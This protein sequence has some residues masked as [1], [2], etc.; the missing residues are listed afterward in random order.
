MATRRIYAQ[1]E[2]GADLYLRVMNAAG[3]WLDFD[4]DAFKSWSSATTPYVAMTEDDDAG[5][6]SR[7][8]Y[9]AD[10][11]LAALN[12]TPE[13]LRFYLQACDNA[14]PALTDDPVS[15]TNEIVVQSGEIAGADE[16]LCVT[17]ACFTSTAGTEI[18]F[19]AW[20]EK[21]GQKVVL[22]AGSCTVTVREHGAGSDLFSVTDSAPNAAGVFELTQASPGFTDDRIYLATVAITVNSITYTTAHAVQVQSS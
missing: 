6:T 12:P 14:S 2:A 15:E 5:G 4:D 21:N 19:L 7:K 1:A 8:S 13:P 16:I 10:L 9:Y 22:S 18:R 3:D 20:L 11:D 17:D